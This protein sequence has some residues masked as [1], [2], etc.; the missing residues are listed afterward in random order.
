MKLTL[1]RKAFDIRKNNNDFLD[2]CIKYKL[3]RFNNKAEHERI[4]QYLKKIGFFKDQIREVVILCKR[5]KKRYG[6]FTDGDLLH[7]SCNTIY[8]S[9]DGNVLSITGPSNMYS[10]IMSN[11]DDYVMDSDSDEE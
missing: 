8:W 10:I 9:S 4:R 5:C 7:C 3:F 6:S 2:Y 11:I 1:N